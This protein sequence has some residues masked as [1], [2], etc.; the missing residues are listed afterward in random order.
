MC[1]CPRESNSQPFYRSA[2]GFQQVIKSVSCYHIAF[3]QVGISLPSDRLSGRRQDVVSYKVYVVL[4]Q[5]NPNPVGDQ[6]MLLLIPKLASS[7]MLYGISGSL[8][9]P[10]CRSS[11]VVNYYIYAH[12]KHWPGQSAALNLC[13]ISWWEVGSTSYTC[14]ALGFSQR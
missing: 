8:E 4:V 10:W 11:S 2:V 12:F 3:T 13:N 14:T 9:Y 1:L 6:L 5:W 7:G